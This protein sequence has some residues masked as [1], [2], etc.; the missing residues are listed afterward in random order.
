MWRVEPRATS[1]SKRRLHLEIDELGEPKITERGQTI[2]S[3]DPH[4][5]LV[6]VLRYL[7]QHGKQEVSHPDTDEIEFEI[8]YTRKKKRR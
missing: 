8:S 4:E 7:L 5:F 1:D 2:A 3:I 6:A